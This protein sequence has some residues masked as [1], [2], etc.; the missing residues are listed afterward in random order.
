MATAHDRQQIRRTL[1]ALPIGVDVELVN[2]TRRMTRKRFGDRLRH[3]SRVQHGDGRMTQ[4]MERKLVLA[5]R[6]QLPRGIA[7]GA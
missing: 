5:A 7:V 1:Q 6:F 3:A 2:S 4:G